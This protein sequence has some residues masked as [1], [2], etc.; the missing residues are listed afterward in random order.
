[1]PILIGLA[2][3]KAELNNTNM[4]INVGKSLGLIRFNQITIEISTVE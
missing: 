2:I 1:M 4:L 3:D